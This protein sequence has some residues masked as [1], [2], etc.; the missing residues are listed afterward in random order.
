MPEGCYQWSDFDDPK[1]ARGAAL[2]LGQLRDRDCSAPVR[3][4]AAEA[5]ES[6]SAARD[7]AATRRLEAPE[8]AARELSLDSPGMAVRAFPSPVS[9]KKNQYHS[10]FLLSAV[11]ILAES[12]TVIAI[13]DTQR[14]RIK[15][16]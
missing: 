1:G 9:Q 10:H 15:S 8:R 11:F 14:I 4:P 16:C 2:L 5:A 13:A 7:D 3:G 6:P 12:L